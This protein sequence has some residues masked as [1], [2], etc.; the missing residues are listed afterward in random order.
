MF[1]KYDKAGAA[2]IGGAITAVLGE[3]TELSPEALAAIG[4]LITTALVWLIPN[5]QVA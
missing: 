4:T 2:V 3:F 5:K 1:T